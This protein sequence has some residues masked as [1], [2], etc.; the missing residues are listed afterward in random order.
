MPSVEQRRVRA[1]VA[2]VVI[3]AIAVAG[4]FVWQRA[5]QADEQ[6][7]IAGPGPT[8]PAESVLAE[9]PPAADEDLSA[10]APAGVAGRPPTFD[11]V[12]ISPEGRAVI[13]GRAEPGARVT[14][15]EGETVIGEVTA[16]ERGEWVLVPEAPIGPG[17]REF[18][19]MART[20]DGKTVESES[21]VVLAVPEREKA[22]GALA[23]LLPREGGV[24]R[25]LQE[26]EG[27]VGIKGPGNLSLDIV[28]YDQDGNLALGGRGTQGAEVMAYLDDRFIGGAK[29]DAQGRWRVEPEAPVPPGLHTLRIDQVG[30]AGKVVARIE[31]PF[32]PAS[33][34]LPATGDGLVIVQPGNSLWR[35]A[36]R[37]YGGGIRY[38]MIYEANRDQIRDPDLIYPGQIFVLP[39]I[40]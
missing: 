1:L 19:L 37:T 34:R 12:R 5:R 13:A 26:P 17:T 2:G 29:V 27:G 18:A 20:R 6:P 4:Y 24:S 7:Q 40:N 22:T 10:A 36:R 23:V 30:S 16:D 3:A 11:V 31:T 39:T 8:A 33:F 32:S 15:T 9:T 14:V 28:D 38:V 25:V 35:I 21:V